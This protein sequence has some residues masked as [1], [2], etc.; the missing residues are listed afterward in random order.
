M[1]ERTPEKSP[2]GGPGSPGYMPRTLRASRK[3]SPTA[4]TLTWATPYGELFASLDWKVDGRTGRRDDREPRGDGISWNAHGEVCVLLTS[5]RLLEAELED[6]VS[7][8]GDAVR[9]EWWRYGCDMSCIAC[10]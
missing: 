4:R 2:P 6:S 8:V 10:E 5:K 7:S 9:E 3:L 1:A